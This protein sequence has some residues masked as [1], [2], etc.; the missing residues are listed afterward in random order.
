MKPQSSKIALASSDMNKF[1]PSTIYLNLG[2]PYTSS[3]LSTLFM[4]IASGLPPHGTKKSALTY[5][6]KWK[7]FLK[8]IPLSILVPQ[9][10]SI[11]TSL[12]NTLNPPDDNL[13][14]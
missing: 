7:L 13:P 4:F 1:A 2:F 9:G 5:Y 3:I 12:I 10:N 14:L 11:F 8:S 6:Y